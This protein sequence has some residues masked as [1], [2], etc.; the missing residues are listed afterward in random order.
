MAS[1][2]TDL[3]HEYHRLAADALL[4]GESNNVAVAILEA[5]E[6]G[7]FERLQKLLSEHQS[8]VD[9]Q[10]SETGDTPLIAA[11]RRGHREVV[12][13]LLSYG[14]D[15]TLE[16][17]SCDSVLD[18]AGDDLRRH[19]LKSITHEDRSMTNAKALLQSAWLGDAVSVKKCLS[20]SHY[21][22]VNSSNKDGLTPLLLVTKDV[23]LF[24]EVQNAMETEY[25][26]VDVLEQLLANHDADVNQSDKFG[27]SPLHMI[28]SAGPSIHA[29]KM[30]S[31]LLQNGSTADGQSSSSL[32]PLH[33][34]S[35]RG[36]MTV[37]V[38]LVEEG[39]ADVNLQAEG[40]GDTP[41]I[42]SVSCL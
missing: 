15:V 3:M 20:G 27:R 11:A 22:D 38:A 23:S 28:A 13:L 21:L 40:T 26:P 42:L 41:L 6:A 33:M 34:A 35:S 31:L 5:A 8:L 36:H 39:G 19:I 2:V 4:G 7:Q 30:V 32:S 24:S 9:A 18:V 12:D 29:T 25:N 16:N 10:D 17:D 37:I 14:A 1:S